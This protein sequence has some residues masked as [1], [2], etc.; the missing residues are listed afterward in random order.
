MYFLESTNKWHQGVPGDLMVKNSSAI[1]GDAGL[2]PRSG[3]RNGFLLQYS[4]LGNPMDRE[5]RQA[6]VHGVTK[7]Q[8][9]QRLNTSISDIILYLSFCLT[10]FPSYNILQVYPFVVNGK[11]SFILWLSS[12]QL[13]KYIYM[14]HL[15]NPFN[16]W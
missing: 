9:W 2:I 13:D 15:F 11:I 6:I 3:E 12:L 1:A 8:T 14:S 5:A 10:Y 7:S 4:C 16:S